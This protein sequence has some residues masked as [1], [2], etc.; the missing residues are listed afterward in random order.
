DDEVL[1]NAL[2]S[3][4][5]V[6]SLTQPHP[7]LFAIIH[8]NTPMMRQLAPCCCSG[9]QFVVP[10]QPKRLARYARND[11]E[12]NDYYFMSSTVNDGW[13]GEVEFRSELLFAVERHAGNML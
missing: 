6:V 9:Q 3:V 13:S 7:Y 2:E 12:L 4:R 10:N 11:G 8:S 5:S 1:P